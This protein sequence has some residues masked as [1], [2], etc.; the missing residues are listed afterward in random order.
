MPSVRCEAQQP[1]AITEILDVLVCS[2]STP[3]PPMES[4]TVPYV[5]ISMSPQ[6]ICKYTQSD[7]TLPLFMLSTYFLDM[8]EFTQQLKTDNECRILFYYSK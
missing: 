2:K 3:H 8:S 4:G 1:S 5:P 7:L 6:P